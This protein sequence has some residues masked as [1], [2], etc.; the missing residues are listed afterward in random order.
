MGMERTL[1]LILPNLLACEEKLEFK[2]KK[3]FS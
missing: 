1:Y 3:M 2:Q